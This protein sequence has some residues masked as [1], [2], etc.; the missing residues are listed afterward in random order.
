VFPVLQAL[1]AA[2]ELG[3]GR[4][5]NSPEGVAPCHHPQEVL[6]EDQKEE[7]KVEQVGLFE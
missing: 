3:T 7:A 4:Q 1:W 2:W 5:G 6:S